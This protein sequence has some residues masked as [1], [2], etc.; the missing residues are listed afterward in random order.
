MINIKN[1]FALMQLCN[2]KKE[3]W[4]NIRHKRPMDG[5][6]V[7][8]IFER[9]SD[10]GCHYEYDVKETFYYANTGFD[11][12]HDYWKVTYWKPIEKTPLP[13]AVIDKQLRNCE[14]NN[15]SFT[16]VAYK[17]RNII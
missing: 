17:R 8:A 4:Y 9:E 2:E 12:E 14:E 3:I 6:I 16:K 10:Y 11:G 7:I 5:E 1:N 13:K 15:C